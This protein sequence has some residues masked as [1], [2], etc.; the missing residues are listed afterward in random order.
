MSET[1]G[2]FLLTKIN[3]MAKWIT[4]EVGKENLPVDII[5]GIAER[6]AL[7][8]TVLCAALEANSDLATHRNWSGLVQ[9]MAKQHAPPELQE[10]VAVVQ[11][12]P[13]M[14]DKFWRYIRL[15]VEVSRQ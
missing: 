3:N 13:P 11:H 4:E 14:H 15:F 12:R 6:S 7:E 8:V 5:A 9:L 1:K 10:I 2:E